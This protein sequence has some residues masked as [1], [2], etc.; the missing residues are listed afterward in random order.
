MC[1]LPLTN[2]IVAITPFVCLKSHVTHSTVGDARL[3]VEG[4]HT[5]KTKES[6][7]IQHLKQNKK[8]SMTFT[9]MAMFGD[10]FLRHSRTSP[11]CQQSETLWHD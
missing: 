3:I 9:C 7:I 1:G 6:Q 5:A 2:S 10:S 4:K 8:T 11:S